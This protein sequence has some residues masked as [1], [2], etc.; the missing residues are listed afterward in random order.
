M[1]GLC[2]FPLNFA[3]CV[4]KIDDL[5]QVFISYT[6]RESSQWQ[7]SKVSY[8][9]TTSKDSVYHMTDLS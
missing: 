9:M 3:I 7:V 1:A 2:Y 8:E 5:T 4:N 6:I